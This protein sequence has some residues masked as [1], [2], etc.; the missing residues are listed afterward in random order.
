[1]AAGWSIRD[2]SSSGPGTRG[3]HPA[4]PAVQAVWADTANWRVGHW[5]TGRIEGCDL[6]LL[7]LRI[8]ADFGFDAPVAVEA[9]AFLDGYV[10]DR[11]LSARAALETLAQVYGLDVSAVA[12]ALH[13]RGPRRDR[14]VVLADADLV[15]LSEDRPVLR[16]VRA[17]ESALPR[18]IELGLTESESPDYRRAAAAAIRPGGR[19]AARDPDRG[20]DRHPPGDR[21]RPRRGDARPG[22][23]RPGQRGFHPEPAPRRAGAR[24]PAGGAGRR[25]GRD[26]IAQ[27]RPDR[28]RP[29]RAADRG[30]RRAAPGRP[31]RGLPRSTALPIGATPAF[32]GPPFAVVLDLPVERGSP[33]VLQY[34]AVAAEPWPG[35]AAVWRAG[36]QG[37]LAL[38]GL[39]DYPAC[40]GRTLTELPAGPLWRLQRG[41]PLD[42]TLRRGGALGSIGE[43][44]MLAG[45]NLFALIGPDGAVELF[46]AASAVLTGP[47]SYRLSGLSARPR[48]Q[49][50]PGRPGDPGGQPDRAARRRR[51]GAPGGAPG[52]GRPGLPLPGRP[53]RPGP[54][55]SGLFGVVRHG[56]LAALRPLRPVHLRARRDASGLRLSWIRRARRDGDAWEPAE[57]PLDE[58]EAY[59]VHG[60]FR[61]RHAPAHDPGRG[62]A[63]PL[64]RRG[65]RFRRPQTSLDVAVAQIGAVAGPGPATRARIPIRTA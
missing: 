24:R 15:R 50:G 21:R 35:A 31:A 57:I 3:P 56:G 17:E 11:P 26:G 27:D 51:I 55:R 36:R 8:L 54:G 9:A 62:A 53:G 13:L 60:L 48:R 47:D 19:A 38:H 42:V 63:G 6:D 30:E 61:R 58:P 7:V 28:R 46:S 18:S 4:F 40:L 64:R 49:R 59:A 52:R 45:G 22:H 5:I 37:A 2:R 44:A 25:A 33:T 43:A 34:L 14:P 41:V 16:Q 10:V 20:G 12:G 23:R 32:P 29:H 65:G 1:M 39:V